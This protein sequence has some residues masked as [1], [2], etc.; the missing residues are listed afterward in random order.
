MTQET[1]LPKIVTAKNKPGT[2]LTQFEIRNHKI[3]CDEEPLYEGNDQ[4]P[5]PYDYVIAGVGGCTAV[6]TTGKAGGLKCEPLKAVIVSR[7][8]RH[9]VPKAQPIN[10]A[11]FVLLL[12][13]V[14]AH[15]ILVYANRRY[16]VASGPEMLS[17][18]VSSLAQVVP[19]YVDRTLALDIPHHL[20][21]RILRRN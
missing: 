4:A 5:D 16:M 7:L 13:N 14:L 8:R 18:E 20:R 10:T 1:N 3:L 21:Y 15:N 6:M 19:C 2:I 17:L 9:L 12:A 11:V